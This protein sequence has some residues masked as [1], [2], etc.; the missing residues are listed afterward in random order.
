MKQ[1]SER[2]RVNRVA[3]AVLATAGLAACGGGE[4][5]EKPDWLGEVRSAQLDGVADDLL[6]AGLGKSGLALSLI[7]I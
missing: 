4:I 7:H 1:R 5:L 2:N 6:T 3:L